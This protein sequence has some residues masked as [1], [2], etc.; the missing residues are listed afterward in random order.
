MT[1]SSRSRDQQR[2]VYLTNGGTVLPQYSL[3]QYGRWYH[4]YAPILGLCFIK[5]FS[6]SWPGYL[7]QSLAIPY[8]HQP[9][10]L[11][12]HTTMIYI[13]TDNITFPSLHGYSLWFYLQGVVQLSASILW[14]Q[15]QPARPGLAA[16]SGMYLKSQEYHSPKIWQIY[17]LIQV[18]PLG[19]IGG[20][21]TETEWF[22]TTGTDRNV[23]LARQEPFTF[24][25]TLRKLWM[26]LKTNPVT[27]LSDVRRACLPPPLRLPS[28]F[29]QT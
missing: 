17:T 10:G 24:W 2:H 8:R 13:L 1:V 18:S 27:R 14:L 12:S 4:F 16:W 9:L 28:T 3:N 11:I 15:S 20:V 6:R 7:L 21:A 29:L 25:T 23:F 26:S 22:P 5:L 19:Q